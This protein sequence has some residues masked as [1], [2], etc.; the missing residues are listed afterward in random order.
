MKVTASA[1]QPG[2]AQNTSQQLAAPKSRLPGNPA[3]SEGR[4]N[5]L[6]GGKRDFASVLGDTAPAHDKRDDESTSARHDTKSSERTPA[7][8]ET[9]RRDEPQ[10]DSGDDKGGFDLRATGEVMTRSEA[11]STEPSARAILHIIDL[12]KI[13]AAVRTQFVAGRQREMMLELSR[14]VLEGLRVRL[15]AD[16]TGRVTAEFF[17]ASEQVHALLDAKSGALADLLS[18]RGVD[19]AALKTSL[20]AGSSTEHHSG[21]GERQ[22]RP[23][24]FST[25]GRI[26]TTDAT[27]ASVDSDVESAL[28]ETVS[29][30][31]PPATYR[32]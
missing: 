3:D 15:S 32:A 22:A 23:D 10:P 24:A 17:A 8:R 7:E 4:V 12:E 16:G 25:A 6:I 28:P 1:N 11:I 14:S 2:Q 20:A 29:G 21:S 31:A 30:A 27:N 5:P 26:P 18:A 19:L 13:V 9:K